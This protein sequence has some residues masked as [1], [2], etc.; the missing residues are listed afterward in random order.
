MSVRSGA[1]GARTRVERVATL[2]QRERSAHAAMGS[3]DSLFSDPATP[4]D[5]AL[6]PA[7]RDEP[8]T[9]LN[10]ADEEKVELP[11]TSSHADALP[12][13]VPRAIARNRRPQ[14]RPNAAALLA[15]GA[16][17]DPS[18]STTVS[19]AAPVP[20]L[21]STSAAAVPS[22]PVKISK[23]HQDHLETILCA[24]EAALSDHGLSVHG[25]GGTLERF[26][27]AEAEG[28]VA[29]KHDSPFKLAH[30]DAVPGRESPR[31]RMN[32]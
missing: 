10:S 14:A 6:T 20:T 16:G 23:E 13:F 21:A 17:S 22:P 31:A 27:E 4:I 7:R 25:R 18:S 32:T 11:A 30:T 12:A 26:K 29:C 19:T 1:R 15:S 2:Q 9:S 8:M 24:I 3:P 5:S 28:K